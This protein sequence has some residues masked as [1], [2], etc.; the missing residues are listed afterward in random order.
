M[1]VLVQAMTG[2]DGEH[3]VTIGIEGGNPQGEVD[4]GLYQ[5]GSDSLLFLTDS[6]PTPL[7]EFMPYSWAIKK[8]Y[9]LTL[10]RQGSMYTCSVVGPDGAL[11]VCGPSNFIPRDGNA[12]SI[13]TFGTTAQYGSVEIVGP[14]Q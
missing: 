10:T 5:K 8:Q 4:C 9:L 1:T 2:T 7:D 14:K 12:V 13:Q 3:S 6:A 11:T